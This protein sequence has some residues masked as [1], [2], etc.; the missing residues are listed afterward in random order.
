MA[1]QND[2]VDGTLK[3]LL[4]LRAKNSAWDK[5]LLSISRNTGKQ[6]QT[7]TASCDKS[8]NGTPR[9]EVVTLVTGR[10]RVG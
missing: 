4:R 6:N 5:I 8:P 2:Y 3:D 1:N 9:C 10:P 7:K